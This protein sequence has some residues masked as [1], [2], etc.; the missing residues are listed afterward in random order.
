[1]IVFEGRVFSVDVETLR[2]PD[3]GDHQVE[4]VRHRPSVVLLPMQ[5][6]DHVIL[7]RQY[8]HSIR[9]PIWELPAGSLEPGEAAE[10][11][12][13]RECEEEIALVPGRVDRLRGVF[14]APGFCDEE[15][16]YFRVSGF[17]PPP[18]DSPHRPD[19]DE[20]IEAQVF[21][22]AEARTMAARGEIIDLKTLY[23]LTLI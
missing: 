16:I 19:P 1:M 3:G 15:L 11:A 9:R 21:T 14:P 2:L 10:A 12:A 18:A 13:R 8:R 5:D 22:I 6:D 23:G 4:T 7:I 20:D 17:R